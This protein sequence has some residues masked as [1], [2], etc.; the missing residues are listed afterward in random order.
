MA[1]KK[2]K[3]TDIPSDVTRDLLSKRIG[4]SVDHVEKVFKSLMVGVSKLLGE[5]KNLEKPKAIAIRR[6]DG[7]FIVG[8]R[9]EFHKNQDDPNN[10]ASGNW[11]YIWSFDE[12]DVTEGATM[13]DIFQPQSWH[14]ITSTA[15]NLFNM[16]FTD[17]LGPTII[18]TAVEHLSHWLDDNA[19]DG[20]VQKLIIDEALTAEC[21]VEDGSVVK[22]IIPDGEVKV[23]IK[24]DDT[25]QD[26]VM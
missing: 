17:G 1:E 4:V 9:V 16:R 19:K 24:G 3:E 8:A 21:A 23:I 2:L 13:I 10:I 5:A 20:E 15:L 26:T 6:P 11:S 22:S 12:T 14:Y 25:Y 7:Q 18:A